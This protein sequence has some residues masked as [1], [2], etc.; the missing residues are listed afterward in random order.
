MDVGYKDNKNM[1]KK[2]KST[3]KILKEIFGEDVEKA[4]PDLCPECGEE[5][6][7][8]AVS[9]GFGPCHFHYVCLKCPREIIFERDKIIA[10]EKITKDELSKKLR[11]SQ[12][13]IEEITK[14]LEKVKNEKKSKN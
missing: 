9:C 4:K 13:D 12:E 7:N 3:D 14:A 10:N 5:I 8:F 11:L 2:H 1:K 6:F